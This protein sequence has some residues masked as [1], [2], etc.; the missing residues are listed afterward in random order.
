MQS[1]LQVHRLEFRNKRK[2]GRRE[3]E[4]NACSRENYILLYPGI[5]FFRRLVLLS[6]SYKIFCKTWEFVG[7]RVSFNKKGKKGGE[8][9]TRKKNT[10][11]S[12]FDEATQIPIEQRVF[13]SGRNLIK[14]LQRLILLDIIILYSLYNM[15][16]NKKK[17]FCRVVATDS[18]W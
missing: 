6:F 13:P 9:D 7:T 1:R 16:T 18:K 12:S 10:R 15:R 2:Y 8:W 3:K 14:F 11:S 17:K 4:R 5:K